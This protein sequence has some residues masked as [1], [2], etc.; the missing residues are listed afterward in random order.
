MKKILFMCINMNVGGTEKAL[1]NLLENIDKD[2]HEI[3]LFMLEKYGGFLDEIP[4]E[5]QVEY[6]D[7]YK[8][9]KEVLN[10]PP[11]QIIQKDLKRM[12]F[13]KA[14][15]QLYY[16]MKTKLKGERSEWYKYVLK[17]T[18]VL[19]KQ[20]DIAIAYAGPAEFITYFIAEKVNAKEKYQWV[21]FDITKI[22]IN[23]KFYEKQLPS[24]K[25]IIVVSNEAK[26]KFEA[27]FKGLKDK[28][29]VRQN[30]IPKTKILE[31]AKDRGFEDNFDGKRIL[32]VGRIAEEKGQDLA[33]ETCKKLIESGENIRW[34]CIGDGSKKEE[35]Q[36]KVKSL[37]IEDSFIFLGTKKNPYPYM[38]ECDI[39]VQPSKHE[40]FC[41]TIGEAK[42]FNIPI[43]TTNFS[44][45]YEQLKDSKQ[46][47]IIQNRDS[48]EL[49]EK[50]KE[51]INKN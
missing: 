37:G 47:Y 36:R 20:Y 2:K 46:F 15:M 28:I 38:K 13:F 8:E 32:T 16:Y 44:G 3:T 31:S 7:N 9:M 51:Y 27:I 34:Y 23:P 42:L 6:L 30:D 50:I 45:A 29:A 12:K 5:I 25:K 14:S 18:K 17:D 19:E 1:L 33:I 49:K 4:K 21:H 39:Y 10:I 41:I 40:G 24:Y 22:S 48:E 26:E 35:Y 11:L 43:I